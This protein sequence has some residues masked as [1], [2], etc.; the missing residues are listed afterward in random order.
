MTGVHKDE[1]KDKN[2]SQSPVAQK[3][4]FVIM[5]IA[6]PPDYPEGHF[7][8]VYKHIIKPCLY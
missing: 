8:R 6:D 5:P 4:C 3:T 2:E 7:G 1:K